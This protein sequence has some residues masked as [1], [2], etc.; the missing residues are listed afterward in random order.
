[1]SGYSRPYL[2]KTILGCVGCLFFDRLKW[3]PECVSMH[4]EVVA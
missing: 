3:D 1:M 4:K 2:G